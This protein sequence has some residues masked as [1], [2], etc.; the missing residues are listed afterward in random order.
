MRVF[1]YEFV[2]GGG[3]LAEGTPPESLRREGAAMLAA[4]AEDLAAARDTTVAVVVAPN[5]GSGAFCLPAACRVV[6]AHGP[7]AAQAAF[8][9]LAAECD[10]TI[11]IAPES[12]GRLAERCR[13]VEQV[14]G[15]L[16]GPGIATVEL[17]A[18]KHATAVRLAAAGVAAPWG[19]ALESG[20]PPPLDFALPAVLKPRF[21]AGSQ[22]VR[23][24]PD[25]SAAAK[26]RARI[27]GPCR[28]ERFCPGLAASVAF[29]CGPAGVFPLPP[30]RQRLADRG[31][32]V[33][34]GGSLPLATPLAKRAV[35]LATRAM[36]ALPDPWGYLGVDLVLGDDPRGR[37]DAVIEINPRLT[38]SYVGLRA[39]AAPGCNLAEAMLAAI[40]GERPRLCFRPVRVEFD[41]FGRTRS[42]H[43][44][45]AGKRP[46]RGTR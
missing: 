8:D 6:E 28:I 9:A 10:G 40:A 11:V 32:F 21:G 24:A 42:W 13:R 12:S 38:T 2:T 26:A 43:E 41:A 19:I 29:L 44:S 46:V 14:G 36:A 33:Y 4:L 30:C 17:A 1:L 23:L 5:S 7:A 20:E 31:Q 37:G 35:R 22:D 18:D 27:D 15:R 45:R 16:L 25:R 34:L 39:A 3:F